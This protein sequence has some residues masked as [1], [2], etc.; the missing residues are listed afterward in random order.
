MKLTCE[1][2]D[3]AIAFFSLESI[4][5]SICPQWTYLP[6]GGRTHTNRN[7]RP[8]PNH[9]LFLGD[10]VTA[11]EQRIRTN[12]QNGFAGSNGSTYGGYASIALSPNPGLTN[13]PGSEP[14]T[15][16]SWRNSTSPR[17]V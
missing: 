7:L 8:A 5:I 1:I 9:S 14:Y 3:V 17:E 16:S 15:N 13:Q 12:H 2:Q 11:V 4:P 10:K 6:I